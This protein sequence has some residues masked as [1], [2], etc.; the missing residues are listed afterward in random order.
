MI[1]TFQ[2]LNILSKPMTLTLHDLVKAFH[3]LVQTLNDLMQEMNKLKRSLFQ[4]G[5]QM[6]LKDI[7]GQHGASTIKELKTQAPEEGKGDYLTQVDVLSLLGKHLYN[8]SPEDLEFIPQPLYMAELYQKPYLNG[9][10]TPNFFHFDGRKRN[11]KE[12]IS[13]FF[14]ALR[15]HIRDGSLRLRQFSKSLTGS[16]YTWY[17]TLA[18]GT[19]HTREE[20]VGKFCRK[21]FQKEE[22]VTSVSLSNT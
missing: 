2:Y 18:P 6:T 1:P 13:R 11:P 8:T 5:A 9:Y 15:Q 4:Q 7:V 14:D 3:G 21:Y 20:M 10:K 12:H 22:N 17:T 19:I 16:A